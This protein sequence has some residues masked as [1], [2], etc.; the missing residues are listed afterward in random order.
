MN[1]EIGEGEAALWAE[2]FGLRPTPAR[3]DLQN[4]AAKFPIHKRN[5]AASRFASRTT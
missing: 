1:C 3:S 2:G 4:H 5:P